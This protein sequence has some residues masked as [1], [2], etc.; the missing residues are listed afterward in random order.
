M[1]KTFSHRTLPA[2]LTGF[3][4]ALL[5][6]T[7][8]SPVA[9]SAAAK[10]FTGGGSGGPTPEVAVRAAT[11]VAQTSSAVFVPEIFDGAGYGSTAE[12]AVR[13]AIG[14]AKVTASAYGLY[15]CELV[16]QPEVFQQ[17]PGSLRA[18]RAHVRMRCDP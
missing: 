10:L 7:V 14:D 13:Q 5:L 15:T 2:A 18:F 3:A 16:E 8:S 9:G 11:R 1:L 12:S 17:P 6:I 4:T